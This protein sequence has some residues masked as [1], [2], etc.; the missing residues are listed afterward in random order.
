MLL[1]LKNTLAKTEPFVYIIL[2]V[3]YNKI[4]S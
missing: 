4:H 1:L 3:H 2:D